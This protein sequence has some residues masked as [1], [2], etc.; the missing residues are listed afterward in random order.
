MNNFI[1][2]EEAKE[3][4]RLH[5]LDVFHTAIKLCSDQE[6]NYE[7]LLETICWAVRRESHLGHSMMSILVNATASVEEA[8]EIS[9]KSEYGPC[10]LLYVNSFLSPVLAELPPHPTNAT[11]PTINANAN[12]LA[13]FHFPKFIFLSPCLI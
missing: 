5:F 13:F 8:I 12:T 11:A 1:T 10:D 4:V 9:N 2:A 3:N 6:D 7:D